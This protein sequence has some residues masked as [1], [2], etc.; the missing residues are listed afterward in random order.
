M[1]DLILRMMMAGLFFFGHAYGAW[2]GTDQLATNVRLKELDRALA[3]FYAEAKYERA[4]EV[5]KQALGLC[6]R[7]FGPQHNKT[8]RSLNHLAQLYRLMGE[9]EKALPLMQR[10]LA[11]SEKRNGQGHLVTGE[12]YNNLALLYD[13]MGDYDKALSLYRRA[14][15]I[16]EKIEGPKHPNTGTRLNN[17][18]GLY[19]AFGANDKALPL[20]LRALAISEKKEGATHPNTAIRLN[21]LAALYQAMG[22][23]DKALPLFLRA[24][25]INEKNEGPYHPTTAINLN[26]LAL[27]YKQMGFYEKALPLYQRALAISEQ[28]DGAEHPDTGKSLNNLAVLYQAMAAYEKALPLYRRALAI[29]EKAEGPT[30][31][32]TAV[33]LSNL[34]G[35]LQAMGNYQEAL[36]LL[37]RALVINVARQG[38]EHASTG[39]RLNNLAE[40]YRLMG[41]YEEALPLYQRALLVSEKTDGAKHPGIATRLNNLAEL[42]R[43]M[44]AY[45]KALPLYLRALAISEN[46]LGPNH[47]NTGTILNNLALLYEATGEYEQ[48]LS[49][50]Q[51]ALLI[52]ENKVGPEHPSVGAMLNN[53]AELYESLGA[54]DKALPLLQRALAISEKAQGAQHPDT[55]IR[56]NNVAGLH[57]VMGNHERALPLYLRALE[58]SEKTQGEE[59]PSL[60]TMLNNLAE[61]HAAMGANEK[62]LP[63]NLRALAIS[64][65][66]NGAEHPMTGIYLNNLA[67]IYAVMGA[68][69]QALPLYHRALEI[70][71]TRDKADAEL[72]ANTA[73]SLCFLHQTHRLNEAIFYCKFA[74]IAHN[75]QRQ[76]V[77]SMAVEL[78]KT[79]T[80]KIANLYLN[81]AHLLNKANRGT[82]A[83]DV[84]L[85]LKNENITFTSGATIIPV[86]KPEQE[87]MNAFFDLSA[88]LGQLDSQLTAFRREVGHEVETAKIE[89][90][91]L[92][93]QKAL[94]QTYLSLPLVLKDNPEQAAK[95]FSP[96]ANI[97]LRSLAGMTKRVVSEETAIINLLSIDNETTL[98][99][100]LKGKRLELNLPLGST[101]ID[102]L[103]KALRDGIL[104]KNDGWRT[105][106][107]ELHRLLIEP[108]EAKLH[109]QKFSPQHL[110]F[111]LTGRLRNI[112]LAVLLGQNDK[113]LT[114]KYSLSLYTPG[115]GLVNDGVAGRDW[116][117][118]AFGATREFNNEKLPALKNVGQELA[119]IVK[120]DTSPAGILPGQ[121]FLD[122]DFTRQTWGL[123]LSGRGPLEKRN[124]LHLAS[125]FVLNP[126]QFTASRIL[127]G[128]G[129]PYTVEDVDA[130]QG[131]SLAHVDL[132]TLS[133]CETLLGIARE[134][135]EFDNLAG[136]FQRK[137]TQAVLASLWPVADVSA[138]QWM[139]EFYSARGEKRKMSKAKAVQTTQLAF[140][141]G[142]VSVTDDKGS[143]ELDLR[144]PFY[145]AQFVL[146]GNWE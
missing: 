49:L 4:L 34:A 68:E 88:R 103:I 130:E 73:D 132:L 104:A 15:A 102:P 2:A 96:D 72:L 32:N 51:R 54:Y 112:P 119:N 70:A 85:A 122:A 31:P 120:D 27:L 83:S 59:H 126:Y 6:E 16:S 41:A 117:V 125:H 109:E 123:A 146:T 28:N 89:A 128:D 3:T 144:H 105:P 114:E 99:M 78:K 138:A 118:N 52:H 110:V 42:Y 30:H 1:R 53:F 21:N 18:A 55:A 69:S 97:F 60:A 67:G 24:L 145:W 29:S 74:V 44:G 66:S 65:R 47:P 111:N 90:Q 98:E 84:L 36:P 93:A 8:G 107:K 142:E 79:F 137:G 62:A 26:N 91:M 46:A 35:L 121:R 50:Y 57:K 23:Y 136:Y 22:A 45:A 108:I 143:K 139:K 10:A 76:A 17:L 134:G 19:Q 82:E 25:A 80:K 133:S 71:L 43:L 37:Q 77:N 64:E 86:T 135:N 38:P 140:L 14:L 75:R 63:F 101:K 87:L 92:Q 40:L 9:Y 13:A 127:L 56:L 124:V 95:Q 7:E 131:L 58:I 48:A 61:L 20:F 100:Y 115:L 94:R 116:R 81:L 106:A 141:R 12:R 39:T 11:I 33:R 5:A 113:F 129:S